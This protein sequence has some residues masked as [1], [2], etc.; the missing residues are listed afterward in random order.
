MD[1]VLSCLVSTNMHKSTPRCNY[2]VQ[3]TLNSL[4]GKGHAA[5]ELIKRY[6][7][8]IL[9]NPTAAKYRRIRIGN[10]AVKNT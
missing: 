2:C 3:H 6:T 8:N 10:P 7:T 4:G 1:D 9:D 5:I